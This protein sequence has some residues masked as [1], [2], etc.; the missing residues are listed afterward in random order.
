MTHLDELVD[1]LLWEGHQ[2]YPYTPSA[3]KN[4]TPTPFGIVY[5]PAHAEGSPHRFARLKLQ[6]IATGADAF[7]ATV[8]FLV[9][10]EARRVDLVPGGEI[11]FA[12]G[13]VQGRVTMGTEDFGGLIR[14]TVAVQN[15]TEVPGGLER[16]EALAFS[17]LS[18][19]V[20]ARCAGGG[21]FLSPI[22]PP[23]EAATAVMTCANVNTYPVLATPEDDAILGA[24][25]ILPDHPQIAPESRG[26]LFDSTE[27]EEA[28]LLHV[29]ALSDGERE[30]LATADPAVRAMIERAVKATPEDIMSLHGRVTVSDPAPHVAAGTPAAPQGAEAD[31]D[32]RGEETITVDGRS[33]H[34]GGHVVLRPEAN[35]N[36]QDHLLAGRSATIERIY[37]DYEDAVHLCVTVDDDPGQDIMRDIGRYLYF[38]PDEVED[39][40]P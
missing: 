32:V 24:A 1:T 33:F 9:C 23:E 16:S 17:M 25:I 15:T 35:R 36:A 28:L 3:T 27:I 30:E 40:A 10:G 2:L 22:A 34:R 6:C 19:H 11:A 21:R 20:V 13:P 7:S 38:K 18:T 26:S 5:P 4:A 8:H 14:V 37:V 31:S 29:L 12:F 39:I